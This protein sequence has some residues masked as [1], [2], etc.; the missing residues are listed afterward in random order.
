M[1]NPYM[2]DPKIAQTV[3]INLFASF[4][5]RAR[6]PDENEAI[7]LQKILRLVQLPGRIN[8]VGWNGRSS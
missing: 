5:V 1:V 8:F 2:T 6:S 3:S 4:S 7:N